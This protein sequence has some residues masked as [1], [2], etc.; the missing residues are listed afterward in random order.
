[1]FILQKTK[2][3]EKNPLAYIF[4]SAHPRLIFGPFGVVGDG[5]MRGL[6]AINTSDNK[7]VVSSYPNS[8]LNEFSRFMQHFNLPS[9]SQIL[10]SHTHYFSEMFL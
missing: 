9:E 2:T 6:D 4:S 7:L 1:M 10:H 8:K 5:F 3:T